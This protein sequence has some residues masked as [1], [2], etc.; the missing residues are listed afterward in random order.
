M[1]DTIIHL[2]AYK[3]T[4]YSKRFQ[5]KRLQREI[6]FTKYHIEYMVMKDTLVLSERK[7]RINTEYDYVNQCSR[8]SYVPINEQLDEENCES[9]VDGLGFYE[10]L[11]HSYS[12]LADFSYFEL[13]CV[14]SMKSFLVSIDNCDF[15]IDPIVFGM[16]GMIF[17]AFEVIDFKTGIPLSTKQ[18]LGKTGNYN[19]LQVESYQYFD[20][21][22]K[23]PVHSK[24]PEIIYNNIMDFL[25]EMIK[26]RHQVK[27][28][29]FI[30]DRLV[31]S[32][33]IENIRES[34]SDL[35]GVRE[36]L[37]P[38]D[39]IS[40]TIDYKYYPQDG[41]SIIT[42]YE[43]K[44][45]NIAI[46]NGIVLETI[47]M[48]IYL[49]Q[50]INV[51]IEEDMNKIIRNDLYVENLFYAPYLP[52]E[53]YNLLDYIHETKSYKQRKEALKLKISYMTLKN[54]SK[55]NRNTVLLNILL[56]FLTL[57]GAI[58]TLEILEKRF[59]IPFNISFCLV[60]IVFVVLGI[61]WTIS[62]YRYNRRF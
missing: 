60:T 26:N 11:F 32:N 16:N 8:F 50:I 10:N 36:I 21:T 59:L 30:H 35:I 25:S 42:D 1:G 58:G 53:T 2:S 52:I 17:I 41:E 56:Y 47:K 44:D 22:E 4:S 48:Y 33:N 7:I 15:Q 39:N 46:Y 12:V 6:L 20:E 45:I 37:T 3:A 18:A 9:I 19:L 54:D 57:V 24:I 27:N 13:E 31:L 40:T 49:S 51:D 5:L 34:F 61:L 14:I 23:K 29:S 38:I 28:Y 55:K 62:E 43:E